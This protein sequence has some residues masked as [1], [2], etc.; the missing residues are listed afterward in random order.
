GKALIEY[1][2]SPAGDNLLLIVTV[3]LDGATQKSK[4]LKAID[5]A[6]IHIQ[7]WPVTPAQLPRWIGARLQQAGLRADSGA[8]DL[9]ASRIEGNLLAAAQ[10]TEK[11][12]LRAHHN[13]V[14]YDLIPP[15]AAD[16]AGFAAFGACEKS[17]DSARRALARKLSCLHLKRTE[18]IMSI[19]V[20]RSGIQTVV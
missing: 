14:R 19:S 5:D 6:G 16:R 13:P 17:V 7:V 18:P 1:A 12:S 15:D 3:K 4:G 10:S 8:I 2:Q 9:L 20:L 11:C